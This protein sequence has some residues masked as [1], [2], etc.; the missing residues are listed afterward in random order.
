MELGPELDSLRRGD[1]AAR[2]RIAL[3]V[4]PQIE[5][6][7]RLNVG[8]ALRARESCSDLVQSICREVL[9][10]VGEYRGD[11]GAQFRAWLLRVAQRKIHMRHR[12]AHAQC[13]DVGREVQLEVPDGDGARRLL[14]GYGTLATPSH[15]LSVREEV[16]RI[17]EAVTTLPDEQ[18]RVLTMSR[19]L[20]L[21]HAEIAEEL[22]KEETAVRKT[23]SRA[24]A[25]LALMLALD[26]EADRRPD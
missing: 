13:R 17:E 4:V 23:L 10:D 1:E 14:T 24:R 6:Y 20:G 26:S 22:G 16:A 3:A 21:S 5:A 2:N 11:A 12:A 7:V 25:R 15:E 8:S 18:R 9:E 19:I